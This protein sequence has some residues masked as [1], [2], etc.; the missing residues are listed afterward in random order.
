[1]SHDW[2]VACRF[3]TVRRVDGENRPWAASTAHA[4]RMGGTTTACGQLAL[5]MVKLF[6][7]RFPASGE[8]CPDCLEAVLAEQRRRPRGATRRREVMER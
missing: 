4:K 3:T 6:E 5:T 7:V 1:V 2:F 8:N